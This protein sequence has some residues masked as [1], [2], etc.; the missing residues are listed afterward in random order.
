MKQA[1]NLTKPQ[2]PPVPLDPRQFPLHAQTDATTGRDKVREV[3][4]VPAPRQ[5]QRPKEG[6]SKSRTGST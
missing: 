5:S 1:N 6:T 4:H 2:S 3:E